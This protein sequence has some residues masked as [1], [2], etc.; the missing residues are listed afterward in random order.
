MGCSDTL[1]EALE[2]RDPAFRARNEHNRAA[3]AAERYNGAEMCARGVLAYEGKPFSDTPLKRMEEM[4][5]N[6]YIDAD[7]RVSRELGTWRTESQVTSINRA[8]DAADALRDWAKGAQG[9]AAFAWLAEHWAF[10]LDRLRKDIAR[11]TEDLK[12]LAPDSPKAIKRR[13]RL[14][15]DVPEAAAVRRRIEW[16]EE[17][18]AKP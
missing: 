3:D 2:S 11:H 5:G 4:I 7:N 17:Q 6:G 10:D 14:A 1:A 13:E 16:A 18:R 12:R 9:H 8:A 15:A